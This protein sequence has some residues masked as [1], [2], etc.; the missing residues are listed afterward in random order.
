MRRFLKK[1]SVS[2]A[3][4]YINLGRL[5]Y[6]LS[7][8]VKAAFY[9]S[10]AEAIFKLKLEDDAIPIGGLN[11]NKGNLFYRDGD[12]HKALEYY[13]NAYY[14][15][16]S[17][18]Q[19]D[20]QKISAVLNNIGS[21]Y[22]Q[23]G[24]YEKSLQYYKESLEISK[25]KSSKTMLFRNLA[26]VYQDQGE[27]EQ[28]NAYFLKSIEYAHENL[29][30]FHYEL[31][32]SYLD[33]GDFLLDQGNLNEAYDYYKSALKVFNISFENKSPQIAEVYTRLGDYFL[34]TNSYSEALDNYQNSMVSFLPGYNSDDIYSFPDVK[35]VVF[36]NDLLPPLFGKAKA[37]YARYQHNGQIGDLEASLT[38]YQTAV[39]IVD[40]IRL[41]LREES[42]LKYVA[43]VR[44][45]F[46]NAIATCLELYSV[47]AD[48]KYLE[49]AFMFSEKSR[50]AVL[51]TSIRQ[52]EAIHIGGI[53]DSL[54]EK[55][56]NLRGNISAY[57]KLIY[58]ERNKI[59][60]SQSKI[61]LWETL[62]FNL[63]K[64]YELLIERFG[65]EYPA[66][67]GLKYDTHVRSV[68]EIQDYLSEDDVLMEY[69]LQDSSIVIFAIT[70]DVFK[71]ISI[72][73]NK[74]FENE[75]GFLVDFYQRSLFHHS[76]EVYNEFLQ[77]SHILYNLLIQPFE[78]II[79]GKNLTIVPDGSLSYIPFGTMIEEIPVLDFMDFRGLPYLLRKHPINYSFS[80][81]ILLEQDIPGNVKESLMAFAP[82]YSKSVDGFNI[83]P[84]NKRKKRKDLDPLQ[85]TE[86]EVTQISKLVNGKVFGGNQATET[87]F[88][89]NA[90]D[91]NI[92]HLAM[93]TIVDDIEP[94]YSRLVFS[95]SN[96][97]V[98]D[99]MLYAYELYDLELNASLAVL[100]ACN[101]GYGKLR[102]GEGVMSLARGFIYAGVPS[103]VMT[104]WEVE[105]KSGAEIMTLFY[106]N[107][108]NGLP[109]SIAL[110]KAKLDYLSKSPQYRAHP[111]FW[112]AY[113][114][115]GADQPL[116]PEISR[117][118]KYLVVVV[119]LATV[120]ALLIIPLKRKSSK[121]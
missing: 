104:L 39:E 26:K 2:L 67:Y 78:S 52:I 61:E 79:D 43:D 47:S 55:E 100:S 110:Q 21:I 48:V 105:D 37:F 72:N 16:K 44:E 41:S 3:D 73:L 17:K 64:E 40:D 56:K 91:Y 1:N 34:K 111:Y 19:G 12:L 13:K 58:D 90:K 60:Q 7:R 113:V 98:N 117:G 102:K 70:K 120:L 85:N 83:N 25:N 101:T 103:I 32:N 65:K 9:F 108:E 112:S 4:L 115:I 82:S 77:V 27:Y 121:K 63:R 11:V 8:N 53:P 29:T 57:E 23:L 97:T 46:Q 116:F 22:S 69:A 28:A 93:H 14:I 51:L 95:S 114:N 66:Y 24:E 106:R 88:K 99:G 50:S 87:N 62:I 10:K 119:L 20:H 33:Y 84:I 74:D 76:P 107:L 94:M 86:K 59:S 92:L 96:D 45:V 38:A 75:I 71:T 18:I 30:K 15:Y 118:I 6:L 36:V 109:K 89:N 68:K 5:N 81:T 35:N 31:G 49:Q 54:I 80:A 42:M